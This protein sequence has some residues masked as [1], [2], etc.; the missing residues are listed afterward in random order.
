MYAYGINYYINTTFLEMK[1]KE[2]EKTILITGESGFIGSHMVDYMVKK[3]PNYMIYGLDALT[4]ASDLRY[5]KHL[6]QLPNYEFIKADIANTDHINTL[7]SDLGITDV[8]HLA[9]ESHVD[10]S[11]ENPMLFVETNVIGTVNILNAFNKFCK[12]R[13]HHV[14]TDEVYGDLQMD[15]PA[16]LETTSYDPSSPYSASKAASDHF[17]KAYQRTYGIDT[18]MTNCSNNYGPHQHM[19]KLIPTVIRNFCDGNDVPVYGAG[20]NVRDWLYVKDHVKAIDM[21]FHKGKSGETYNVGGSVE[22]TNI[23]LVKLIGSI[24]YQRGYFSPLY[25]DQITFVKDR[26]GHDFRYAIDSSKLQKELGW[27]PNPN[28][29]DKYLL[30]TVDYYAEYILKLEHPVK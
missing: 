29:F 13:F 6:R 10:N 27:S 3:Y 18:T 21:V 30:E 8:I 25:E 5:T 2:Y 26:A 4:Y 11:I 17:V 14:S 12:G 9:A 7:F 23:D 24:G 1:I 16:F 22:M 28:D 15:D 20:L 19:E